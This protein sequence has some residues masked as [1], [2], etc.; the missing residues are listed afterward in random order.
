MQLVSIKSLE[1]SWS[2]RKGARLY[3]VTGYT[4]SSAMEQAMCSGS[5]PG[6]S[7]EEITK[8]KVS[9]TKLHIHRL[10][11]LAR[12]RWHLRLLP[13]PIL[14]SV[15]WMYTLLSWQ[16][17]WK[18]RSICTP[19]RDTFVCSRMGA[20]TTIPDERLHGRWYSASEVS[21]WP[22]VVCCIYGPLSL[23]YGLWASAGL[24]HNLF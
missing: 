1:I 20:N 14:R 13:R 7:A 3:Q 6:E 21:L 15:K 22:E 8:P 12:L 16:L 19:H 2:F 24:M 23:A 10:L 17:T 5:R 4:R 11:T 18:K 9:T